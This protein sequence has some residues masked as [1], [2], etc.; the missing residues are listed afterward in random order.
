MGT[1]R[2]KG[3]SVTKKTDRKCLN[4][5]M[6]MD[7]HHKGE[8]CRRDRILNNGVNRTPVREPEANKYWA[9]DLLR[10]HFEDAAGE[11]NG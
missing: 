1:D 4:L 5:M 10:S 2:F 11:T 6:A 3:I 8:D 7:F 9:G